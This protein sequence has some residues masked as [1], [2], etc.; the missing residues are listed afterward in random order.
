MRIE[1]LFGLSGAWG[2]LIMVF[3]KNTGL[4][5]LLHDLFVN[6]L[7]QTI[8]LIN[9]HCR[10]NSRIKI[11]WRK[12]LSQQFL[13]RD[14]FVDWVGIKISLL[15]RNITQSIRISQSINL[16]RFPNYVFHLFEHEYLTMRFK[17]YSLS[18]HLYADSWFTC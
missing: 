8:A 1:F 18:P 4:M 17:N 16:M 12:I 5:V 7:N 6:K 13:T 2:L 10:L 11:W 14:N 15:W 9:T 3:S